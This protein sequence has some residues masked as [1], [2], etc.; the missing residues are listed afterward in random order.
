MNQ[1]LL[2]EVQIDVCDQFLILGDITKQMIFPLKKLA[3]EKNRTT[4]AT[5]LKDF[6]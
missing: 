3:P 6:G 1:S 2:G 4:V 5:I